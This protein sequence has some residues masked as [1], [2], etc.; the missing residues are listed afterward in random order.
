MS[1]IA[2]DVPR[3]K[4]CGVHTIRGVYSIHTISRYASLEEAQSYLKTLI[5]DDVFFTIEE[6]EE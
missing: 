2:I 1:Y 6:H 4:T 5:K 3:Q